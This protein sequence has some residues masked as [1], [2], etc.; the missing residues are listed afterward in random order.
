MADLEPRLRN[1]VTELSP[2]L[3]ELLR[4]LGKVFAFR[5]V[6]CFRTLER[7]KWLK[8]HGKSWTLKSNHL[9]G[10]A[11]DLFPIP[12]GYKDA[13]VFEQMHN[14]W[15]KLVMAYHAPG[16]TILPE[17]RIGKDMGHFGISIKKKAL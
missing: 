14:T 13:K 2:H 7:Q 16:L 1:D 3:Q 8:A 15:D 4:Q 17:K 9:L 11:A 10:Q 6:E 5:T 12:S